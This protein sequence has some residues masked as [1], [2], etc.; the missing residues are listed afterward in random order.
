MAHNKN[1]TLRLLVAPLRSV[2]LETVHDKVY[3]QVTL[4]VPKQDLFKEK[5][6]HG[7]G[8]HDL[9]FWLSNSKNSGDTFTSAT[10]Q[11]L[12]NVGWFIGF[13]KLYGADKM[14]LLRKS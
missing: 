4:S 14:Y 13:D 11:Q 3:E 7:R 9:D 6:T 10:R 12:W 5:K 1:H 8:Y 2:S